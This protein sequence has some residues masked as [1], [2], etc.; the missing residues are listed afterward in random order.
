M[1]TCAVVVVVVMRESCQA[2]ALCA[3]CSFANYGPARQPSRVGGGTR[4]GVRRVVWVCLVFW[5]EAVIL[6]GQHCLVVHTVM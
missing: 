4:A 1:C 2:Y 3:R 5:G 6:E